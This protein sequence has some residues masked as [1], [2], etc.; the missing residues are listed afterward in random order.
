MVHKTFV[1]FFHKVASSK[2][3][4]SSYN[5]LKLLSVQ[6]CG[7]VP[8]SS[9]F[10]F[11]YVA[12]HDIGQVLCRKTAQTKLRERVGPKDSRRHSKENIDFVN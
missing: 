3:E 8:N 10:G 11:L 1:Y 7:D 12:F 6:I 5:S 4:E 2:Q 9:H